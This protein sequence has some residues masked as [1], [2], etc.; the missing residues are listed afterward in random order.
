MARRQR[1]EVV[2]KIICYTITKPATAGPI[3]IILFAQMPRITKAVIPAAGFGTRFLPATK[4]QPKEMLTVVDKPVIQY[5]VEEAVASGITDIII[6]TGQNKRA[7]EDHFDRSFELEVRLRE[8]KKTKA[9]KEVRHIAKLANFVYVRQK[10]IQGDGQAILEA[11]SL[12]KGEPFAV[13]FGDDIIESREPVLGKLIDIYE[14]FHAPVIG[15]CPVARTAVSRYGIISGPR[16][17]PQLTRLQS[18]VEKP[19]P[20]KTRSNLAVVGR[21]VLTPTFLEFLRHTPRRPH[22]EL[23]IADALAI[24]LKSHP[25]YAYTFSGTWHDCGHKLGLLQ[26]TVAHGLAHPEFA[27]DFMRY[28]R[29]QLS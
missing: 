26:A 1:P 6:I 17:R 29:R 13:L 22:R 27:Q 3:Y 18:L 11:Y 25:A 21:Y 8:Q 4:A 14:E 23:R 7:I 2:T 24:F 20:S 15:V 5:I 16:V 10:E 9:L 19:S 28:L 12:L